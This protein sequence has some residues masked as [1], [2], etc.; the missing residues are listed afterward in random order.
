MPNNVDDLCQII[1]KVTAVLLVQPILARMITSFIMLDQA[2]C[3]ETL[4]RLVTELRHIV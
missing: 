1:L 3:S 4:N 2:A